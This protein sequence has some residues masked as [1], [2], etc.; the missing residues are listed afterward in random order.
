MNSVYSEK[1]P[2]HALEYLIVY[3]IGGIGYSMIEVVTRGYTHWS[4]TL[5]GGLCLLI[6]YIHFG[7][8]P[9]EGLLTKCLFGMIVITSLEFIVGCIVNLLLGWNVWDYSNM[10]MNLLGQICLAFS[11]AWFLLGVPVSYLC[12][13][14][15]S[16]LRITEH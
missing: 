16:G 13:A 7:R 10:H 2:S 12:E 1:K 15:R 6:M 11:S 3:L 5:T 8:H 9:N 14:L 4:M